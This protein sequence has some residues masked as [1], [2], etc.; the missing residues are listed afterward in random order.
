MKLQSVCLSPCS[1]FTTHSISTLLLPI[2]THLL[3]LKLKTPILQKNKTFANTFQSLPPK[4]KP[5]AKVPANSRI[6][7]IS[8]NQYNPDSS[9]FSSK[10]SFTNKPSEFNNHSEYN[11]SKSLCQKYP[12]DANSPPFIAIPHPNIENLQNSVSQS[13]IRHHLLMKQ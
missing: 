10:S 1:H 5:V 11:N 13:I 3:Y 7:R 9:E 2:W 12:S 8:E 4:S 6:R